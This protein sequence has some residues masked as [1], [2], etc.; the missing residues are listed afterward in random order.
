M[1]KEVF[2]CIFTSVEANPADCVFDSGRSFNS[3]LDA[4]LPPR[5]QHTVNRG[6]EPDGEAGPW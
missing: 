2:F 3:L 1:T 6:Q 5:V 4:V